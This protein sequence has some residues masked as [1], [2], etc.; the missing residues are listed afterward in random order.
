METLQR[1]TIHP[2]CNDS[3]TLTFW[4]FL[5]SLSTTTIVIYATRTTLMN[6]SV[7]DMYAILLLCSIR[8]FIFRATVTKRSFI[9]AKNQNL[10]LNFCCELNFCEQIYM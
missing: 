6:F 3:F 9:H 5:F 2:Y 1:S 10:I 7:R 8:N 4:K